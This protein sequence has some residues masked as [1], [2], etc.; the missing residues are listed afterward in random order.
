MSFKAS[1]YPPRRFRHAALCF[2]ALLW[3]LL[4]VYA[5]PEARRKQD[6]EPVQVT[7]PVILKASLSGRPLDIDA[8]EI[9]KFPHDFNTFEIEFAVSGVSNETQLEYGMRLRGLETDWHSSRYPESRYTALAPGF[10]VFE[11]RARMGSGPWSNPTLLEFEIQRPWWETESAIAIWVVAALML[12]LWPLF[13]FGKRARDLRKLVSARTMELA[14][15]NAD[16]QR[17]SVT[18]PLT[19]LKNRRFVEFSIG[20]DLA[21]V[22]RSRVPPQGD[23]KGPAGDGDSL[24]FLLIDIDFFKRVNDNFGHA[25]GDLVLRQM[26]AIFTSAVRESDMIVRWGGEEFLIIAR[27]SQV[28]DAAV[29]AQRICSQV[30]SAAFSVNREEPIRLTCS[31]GF[32]SWPFFRREPDAV[33]WKDV[34][35]LA[36]RCLYRWVWCWMSFQ[37]WANSTAWWLT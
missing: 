30:Q 29:L 23:R 34:L 25:A 15:A 16:L 35:A 21:Q 32:A 26:S 27:S 8:V 17:H 12:F 19:G 24:N 6:R 11:V 28:N 10:Y 3:A 20:E 22:R 7:S 1:S 9:R 14:M 5:S 33:G 4:P 31:I 37:H 2:I 13:K 36:D 18:D